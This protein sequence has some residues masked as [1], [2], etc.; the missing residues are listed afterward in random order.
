MY[1]KCLHTSSY[2]TD[3]CGTPRGLERLAALE[4][5]F[6]FYR[7]F[8]AGGLVLLEG[9]ALHTNKRTFFR[10]HDGLAFGS[11]VLELRPRFSRRSTWT[12][13]SIFSRSWK[14]VGVFIHTMVDTAFRLNTGATYCTICIFSET[15]T[16]DVW[17]QARPAPFCRK[18][19]RPNLC[20]AR[21]GSSPRLLV[22]ISRAP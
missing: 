13:T 10:V 17:A 15:Q 2:A 20:A 19:A 1:A 4:Y 9:M 16:Q 5:A 22:L 8:I 12:L 11:T 18:T 21:A 6:R 7:V 14:M 3:S